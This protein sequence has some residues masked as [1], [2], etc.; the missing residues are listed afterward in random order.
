MLKLVSRKDL[1]I[2]IL[3]SVAGES[4]VAAKDQATTGHSSVVVEILDEKLV[5]LVVASTDLMF[6]ILA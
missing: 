4:W 2:G 5:W 6:Q 1:R 3:K